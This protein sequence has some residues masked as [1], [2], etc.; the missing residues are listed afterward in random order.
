MYL[1]TDTNF[2]QVAGVTPQACSLPFLPKDCRNGTNHRPEIS[3]QEAELSP[4][5]ASDDTEDI[6]VTENCPHN[7]N[8]PAASNEA[9]QGEKNCSPME[10]TEQF[11]D[12]SSSAC[13]NLSIPSVVGIS[14]DS[15]MECDGYKNGDIHSNCQE[16]PTETLHRVSDAVDEED[17]CDDCQMIDGMAP[18]ICEEQAAKRRRLMP[19]QCISEGNETESNM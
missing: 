1:A 19:L 7:G 11:I 14:Q 15:I 2:P 6:L 4:S 10:N 3:L 13:N 12:N 18:N 8:E 9:E 17:A 5:S 16:T